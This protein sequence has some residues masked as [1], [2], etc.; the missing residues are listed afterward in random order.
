MIF[1]PAALAQSDST[2]GNLIAIPSAVTSYV[3]GEVVIGWSPD[4]SVVPLGHRPA[5]QLADDRTSPDWQRASQ[6]V[7]ALTSL[8]VIDT[9]PEYGTALLAVPS[10]SEQAEIARLRKLP[11]VRY[12]EPNYIASAAAA[13]QDAAFYPDDPDIGSQWNMRRIDAPEAWAVTFGSSSLVVAVIDSGVDLSH[14]EFAAQFHDPLLPGYDYVN[15]DNTP[16]DDTSNSHGTHVTGILAA[17]AD[18][19][20]GVA[21][22]APRVKIL[23]LKV[24]DSSGSGSYANIGTA[25]RRAAD[26]GAAVI[27]LSLG[28]ATYS[29]SLQDA[30]NYALNGASGGAIVVAA[31]GNCAQG[32]SGCAGINPDFY[33][34]AYPG[35]VAVAASDHFDNWATYSGYKSYVKLA[36][37]GGVSGDPI[38]STVRGGYGVLWGTSMA[39]PHVSAAAALAWTMAPAATA[40]QIV[41]ILTGTADKVGTDPTTGQTIPYVNGRND[42]FGCGRL[43]VGKAVRQTYPPALSSAGDPQEFLLGGAVTQQERQVTLTNPSSQPVYWQATVVQGASWLSVNP[44]VGTATYASP[45]AFTLRATRGTLTPALYVGTIQVQLLYDTSIPGFD[46]PVQ[47]RVTN[48]LSRLYLPQV[49]QNWLTSPWLDPFAPGGLGG[50]ALYLGDNTASQVTL[51][52]PV[53]FYAAT[54]STMWISDNGLVAFGA[55]AP[56][57]PPTGCLPTAATPNNAVYVLGLDWRPDQGGQVYVHQ[58]DTDTYVVTWYQIKRAGSSLA[59]SFQLVLRRDGSITANYQTVEPSAPGIVGVENYDGTVAQQ[60]WCNGAGHAVSAGDTMAFNPVLPW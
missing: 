9:Q 53:T 30:V 20:I 26:F 8:Q 46:V 19:G 34:A 24:L 60:I 44:A 21:G 45:G 13:P 57:V 41:D 1:P 39:A 31:A 4:G 29:Y 11:W 14:P 49:S 25:I 38:W 6:A 55:V 12:A 56:L 48:A 54:Y 43:N 33:P 59:Q 47:L 22:L 3:P 2:P 58:P 42:Y 52:F 10:G 51:P 17:A 28:G 37:P 15:N 23:P 40:Q 16:N 32:A 7:A 50:S 35:V 18:N 27:N 36:A 5:R